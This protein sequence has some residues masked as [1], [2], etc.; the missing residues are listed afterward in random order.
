MDGVHGFDDA[1]GFDAARM[2][3]V[4]PWTVAA[5]IGQGSFLPV[6]LVLCDE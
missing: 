1:R 6:A 5:G 2:S 4:R 3:L